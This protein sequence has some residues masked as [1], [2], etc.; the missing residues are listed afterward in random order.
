MSRPF[1]SNP[2]VQLTL[3]RF[4][5]FTR[6]PEAVF[7]AV[8][9]PI[10]LTV[11]LGLAFRDRPDPV[12]KIAATPAVAAS[13][14][15]EPGLDVR[16]LDE[17]AARVALRNGDVAL[18]VSTGE[19]GSVVFYFDD[20]NTEGRVARS[21]ADRAIQQAAG[22]KDPV[23]VADRVTKEPGSRYVD[24]LV[25][26]LIGIGIMSN[27]VWGLGFSIVDS[28]RR[29]LIKRMV[30]TPMSRTQ[31]LASYLV[32]RM[33]LLPVEV[34]IPLAF[35]ALAFDVPI[36][37]SWLALGFM[38]LLGSL[39]F[40][41]LG[42][43]VGSRA[44]TIEAV[45]GIMNLLI[46]PQWIVSGVFFSAQRFPDWAQLPIKALPLTALIDALRAIQLRGAGLA[47]VGL[48]IGILT[49]WFVVAFTLGL[50]LFRWR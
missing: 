8:F 32:W 3:V 13:L 26:G 1:T 22:R 41:A 15:T 18:V 49:F 31:Y 5:E 16:E 4:R 20:T 44:K 10:L 33:I 34:V 37:G 35:G 40:S 38:C 14:R 43:L 45:S 36:R 21:L 30:A 46:M 47:D 19:A 11:G 29:K 24:F 50:K 9:F 17:A 6:E 48:E 28:R 27:A 42:V 23:A 2:L 25:A 12:L 39:C 7:W